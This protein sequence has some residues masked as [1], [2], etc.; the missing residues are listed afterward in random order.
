MHRLL[1][2]LLIVSP[3]FVRAQIPKTTQRLTLPNGWS[4]TPVG[5][6]LPLGDLPLNLAVSPNGKRLAVTNNGQ[7]TQSIQLIDVVNEKVLSEVEIKKSW[8]GLCFSPDGKR[9]LASGGND[10][11]VLIYNVTG[12]Q[13]IKIDSVVLG[14]P[15]PNRLWVAGI[16]TDR[17]GSTLYAVTKDDS[18]LYVCDLASKQIKNRIKLPAEGYT[19]LRQPGTDELYISLW[20]AEKVVIYDP[21]QQKLTGEIRTGSHPNDMVFT[22]DRKYLFVANANDNSVSVIDTK[23]RRVL[24]IITTSLYPNAL[25]GS[26]PNGL[27]LTPDGETLLVANADNN[28]LAVFNVEKPGRSRSLGFIPTGWY[29][30]AVK[31]VGKKVMV[32]N[33]KGFSS[34]ANP[35]G[36]NPYK[37]RESGTEYI[38]GLFKGTLSLFELPKATDLTSLSKLVYENTPYTKEKEKLAAG[39]VNNPIPR[40]VGAK[41]SPIKYVFYIIKEN[42][43]YDQVFGDIASGNGDTSLCIFPEKITPN[44]HALAREF[45]LLDNFYVDAEVSADGHNWST[46]AYATDYVEKV[47][48]TSYGGRGGTYDF[49]GSRP[50]AYPKKGFIWDYCERAGLRYRS[51]GEFEAYAKRKGSA[52]DGRFA[53]NYPDYDLKIKDIDRVEIWKKDIDSLIASN[54]VPHF[55]SIRLGN[56]HTSGARI[57]APTPA[58]HVADNDLAVGRFVEHLSK[59]SIWKESAV[60]ILEDDAQ[61]GADHV[62]AHRSPAL[63]IS[64]YTK[65]R[66]VEHSMYS[67]SGMLRTIELILGLPPMSQYD[68]AALPM[69]ACFTSTPTLTPYTH[70]PANV[71][72]E[73]KNT[74]MTESAKQSQ[75]MD[76]RYADKIDDRLFNEIIWKAVKG[77]NSVMPA[78]KRGAFVIVAAD[79][80]DDE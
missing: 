38:A 41:N 65:R 4:L 79:D 63:V 21:K 19:C 58:A 9:L 33:G 8:V 56:D 7:S 67:T 16:E 40:E 27:A 18:T 70:L 26:T 53:P 44:Q 51:Y 55:S 72:L 75:K 1:A 45:V 71:D 11:R 73:A 69:F 78:P 48:P 17:T 62:D 10:N 66:H 80:D 13:L 34:Q 14:K 22:R 6:S 32:A 54:A 49:E 57:G 64:P 68:A 31:V 2:F 35:N 74:A 30:T 12:D 23:T 39:E 36:P 20:G 50:T 47:W 37:R 76:L 42:R 5:R 77:E 59:S 29:P 3:L 52:L 43:T 28:C 24:E 61:N 15:W 46:A 60:F 25:A